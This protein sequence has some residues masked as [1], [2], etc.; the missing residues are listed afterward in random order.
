[1]EARPRVTI[2]FVPRECFAQTERSLEAIYARTRIPFALVCVDAGSPPSV[3]RYLEKAAREKGFTLIRSEKYLV[4]NEARNLVIGRVKTEYVAFV[5][6]DALV[7]PGW[8]GPLVRCADETGAWAVGP[9]YFEYE[10][11]RTQLHMAGGTC[12]IVERADGTRAMIERHEHSHVKLDKLPAKPVR[13]ATE[14][15]EFHTMLVRMQAFAELGPLDPNLILAEHADFC[16][17]VRA[18]GHSIY[19]EPEAAVT[20]LPPRR[21]NRFDRD[22]FHFRWSEK[23]SESTISRLQDKYRLSGPDSGVEALRRFVR[24]HRTRVPMSRFWILEVGRDIGREVRGKLKSLAGSA[25]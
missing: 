19:L 12:R 14:L 10:P 6:N 1:M 13:R 21:A 9:L 16:L 7:A 15:L 5:D 3:R 2:G 4:P 23:K 18:A 8:L 24:N 22:Y 25:S 20:Y 11:E 17:S